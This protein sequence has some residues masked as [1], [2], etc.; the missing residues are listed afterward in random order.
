MLVNVKNDLQK[1]IAY[2]SDWGLLEIGFVSAPFEVAIVGNQYNYMRKQI[3]VHYLPNVLLYGG[4]SEGSLPL[5]ESKL[6]EGHTTIY[7]CEDKSCK[8]PITEVSNALELIIKQ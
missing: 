5:L 2:Y 4:H 6:V 1:N 8:K 7:V 3:D